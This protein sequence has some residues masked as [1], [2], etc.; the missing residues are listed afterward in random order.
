V[1]RVEFL[2][3]NAPAVILTPIGA[4]SLEIIVDRTRVGYRVF[5]LRGMAFAFASSTADGTEC[6]GVS[7]SPTDGNAKPRMTGTTDGGGENE[8]ILSIAQ[9]M[10]Q[11]VKINP[12]S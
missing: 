9:W 5:G 1:A 3:V 10:A 12:T 8:W 4:T 2:G 7:F 11:D 6:N